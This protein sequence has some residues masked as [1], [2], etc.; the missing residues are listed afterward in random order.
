MTCD[1]LSVKSWLDNLRYTTENYDPGVPTVDFDHDQESSALS[2][3]TVDIDKT[4]EVNRKE[5]VKN[6]FRENNIRSSSSDDKADMVEM[7]S[8]SE[9]LK[10]LSVLSG[11]YE[12]I[13]N[14]TTVIKNE[15]DLKYGNVCRISVEFDE[16]VQELCLSPVVLTR[17][18]FNIPTDILQ[19]K[20]DLLLDCS[21]ED[22]DQ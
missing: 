21:S 11:S 17:F 2:K 20:S 16:I 7:D 15:S 4:I 9:N 1:Q 13:W 5:I 3:Q 10:R 18:D 12:N 19:W 8:E 6:N 22:E 14:C